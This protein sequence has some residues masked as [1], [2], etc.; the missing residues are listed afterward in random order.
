MPT[1]RDIL[2]H[3]GAGVATIAPARTVIE[4]AQSM[5]DR[6]I[7][8]LVVLRDGEVIGMFTERDILVR[9]VAARKDPETT[10]VG[11]VMTTPIVSCTPDTPLSEC[12]SM[13]TNLRIRHI[14]VIEE[15]KLLGI[16]TSGDV[17]ARE[18]FER[19]G[20]I[21]SLCEYI[22]GPGVRAAQL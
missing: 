14:P 21:E 12:K 13:V 18:A 16:V 7:G 1:V 22:G 11:E 20:T 17:V 6:R 19:E 3:K 9:V 10:T 2:K 5:N 8:S 15:G 4:A